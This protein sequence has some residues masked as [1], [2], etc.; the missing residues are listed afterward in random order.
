MQMPRAECTVCGDT[1]VTR[2]C[3]R[4]MEEQ[5]VQWLEKEE[6][7][8]V[9]RVKKAAE[10]FNTY[11]GHLADCMLCGANLNVCS[12]CYTMTVHASLRKDRLLASEF[13]DFA[14]GK[15]FMLSS[16]KGVINLEKVM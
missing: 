6:P 3:H 16:R 1:I 10:A 13:L 7:S 2:V 14:A 12:K 9:A 8:Q 5:V 15:G 11:S 4:C